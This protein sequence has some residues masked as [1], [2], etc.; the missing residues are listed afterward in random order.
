MPSIVETE[1]ARAEQLDNPEATYRACADMKLFIKGFCASFCWTRA[2]ATSRP[3]KLP[4]E[5]STS[6]WH[7]GATSFW[8]AIAQSAFA[9]VLVHNL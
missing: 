5:A 7:I 4:G 6:P 8:P 2:T 1:Y 9:F 3:S